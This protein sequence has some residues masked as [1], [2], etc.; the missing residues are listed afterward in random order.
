MEQ[1]GA[2]GRALNP[3]RSERERLRALASFRVAGTG[4]EAE[5]DA[6]AALT[7]R[8]A[9]APIG[10]VTF[11]DGRC[12]WVKATNGYD[13]P[14]VER[15]VSFGDMVIERG[16]AVVV[17]DARADGHF[18]THPWV[19]GDPGVRFY[20]GVPLTAPGGLPV[21][22]L[23]V[24][25]TEPRTATPELVEALNEAA[26]V[27][28]PHLERRREEALA[29]NLTCIIGFDGLFQRVS[30]AFETVLGWRP[31]E[32]V[33]RSF[34]DFVHPDDIEPTQGWL[35]R[36]EAERHGAGFEN[37]YRCKD[38]TYRWLLWNDYVERQERRF[39][40]AARDISDRKH[41]ELALRKSEARYRLL[42]ENAT[43]MIAGHSLDGTLT[44]VSTA[45]EALTGF[46]PGELVGVDAYY[47]IHPDDHDPVRAAHQRLLERM[48]PMRYA[49]RL[50]RKDESWVWVETI[51]R[52]VRDQRSRPVALQ[53]ATR[54]I[55]ATHSAHAALEAA[56]EHFRRAF[57]DA[58]I[59]MAIIAPGGL[60]ERVNGALCE[61]L[62]YSADE[63]T[64]Q[65]PFYPIHPDDRGGEE[66]AMRALLA[67]EMTTYDAVKRHVHKDGH[68]VW[69]RITASLMREGDGA[70]PRLLAHV[71]DISELQRAREDAER[72]NRAKSEFLS[73]MSHELR[74]P[75][76]SVLGFAQL[77]QADTVTD[78]QRDGVERILS[79]GYHLL[80]LVNDVLDISAIEAGQLPMVTERVDAGAIVGET[81]ELM[82]PLADARSIRLRRDVPDAEVCVS[83]SEQRLKQ[84]LL[85]LVSNAI[86]YSPTESDVT[87]AVEPAG[88]RV[89]LHVIDSG[90][91]IA[92]DN[93]ERAFLPF[94][95]LGDG[96]KVEGT[97]LG[98]PLSRNLVQAMGGSLTVESGPAGSTFTAELPRSS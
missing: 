9:R 98:L 52:V 32:M 19:A 45:A 84:V 17:D 65:P 55:S 92:A 33:G 47:L 24:M 88:D 40:S 7:A 81:L 51:A 90:P 6:V 75:L 53:S 42:A 82:Q 11:V 2:A 31:D 13:L 28:L 29:Q 76:N 46:R 93:L 61:L 66:D 71:Q 38:G 22:T 21:G 43:D 37:R 35:D 86:K 94:E 67:G 36:V 44:Y 41:N 70:E 78:A 14:E 72:A 1:A 89:R 18:A 79:G 15:R 64:A 54:D 20:A 34:V 16:S 30:T 96:H 57:D 77:L 23:A 8:L 3:P 49:Y 73:R 83:A 56:R 91:G 59:G 10:T 69:A 25:D 27:L 60:L 4:P 68:V 87:V 62:G 95:R 58:P 26:A 48:R 97:G 63:L 50:R 12:E 5:F 74:T 80:D 39:Y 85:N